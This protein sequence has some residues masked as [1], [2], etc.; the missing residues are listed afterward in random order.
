M[1]TRALFCGTVGLF[2]SVEIEGAAHVNFEG[3]VFKSVMTCWVSASSLANF[4]HLVTVRHNCGTRA[5]K[6][7][8]K[9]APSTRT[10][11]APIPKSLRPYGTLRGTFNGFKNPHTTRTGDIIDSLQEA[12]TQSLVG[13]LEGGPKL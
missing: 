11:T 13:P 2:E 6:S 9:D 7:Q 1:Q 8:K 5:P 10:A 3:C 12:L 4:C